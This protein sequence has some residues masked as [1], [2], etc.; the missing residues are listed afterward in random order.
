MYY[1]RLLPVSSVSEALELCDASFYPHVHKL[2]TI[3]MTLPVSATSAEHSFSAVRRQK[4][5]LRTNMS[6]DRSRLV[7]LALLH[8]HRDINVGL[9]TEQIVDRFVKRKRR[10]D[11]VL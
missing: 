3:L 9:T 5:W 4:N 8:M 1:E 10:V 6:Q 7:G 11:F 2:L